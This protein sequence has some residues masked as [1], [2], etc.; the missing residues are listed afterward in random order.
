[1]SKQV[2]VA[3]L[4][5][6]MPQDSALLG[7][8]Y[9]LSSADCC[10]FYRSSRLQITGAF[11][12][13]V[14]YARRAKGIGDPHEEFRTSCGWVC[15]GVVSRVGC[16]FLW[17]KQHGGVAGSRAQ[18][19]ATRLRWGRGGARDGGSGWWVKLRLSQS[20]GARMLEML[21]C[22]G[23]SWTLLETFLDRDASGGRTSGHSLVQRDRGIGRF[24]SV[25]LPR[26]RA[27][28]APR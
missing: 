2:H 27:L 25:R 19:P 4:T 13:N 16:Q 20:D 14:L 22:D 28:F 26:M 8:A 6:R 3:Q 7:Q 24:L 23:R 11:D 1:M 17:A 9:H 5:R 15:R 12:E 10:Q 18:L 21:C